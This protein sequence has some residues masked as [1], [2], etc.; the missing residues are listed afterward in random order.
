MAK[1]YAESVKLPNL[2]TVPHP[3]SKLTK[4]GL[5]V[6]GINNKTSQSHGNLVTKSLD[7]KSFIVNLLENEQAKRKRQKN[8]GCTSTDEVLFMID[9]KL[10][11][12]YYGVK[13]LFLANNSGGRISK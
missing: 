1:T 5:N 10:T 8:Q 6:E 7:R 4:N 11:T 3:A 13:H 9:E 2:V 12:G